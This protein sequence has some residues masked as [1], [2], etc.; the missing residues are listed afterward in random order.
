MKSSSPASSVVVCVCGGGGVGVEGGV[1]VLVGWG[2]VGWGVV[3]DG[4][5]GGW[6]WWWVLVD[7]GWWD[8]VEVGYVLVEDVVFCYQAQLYEW[9]ISNRQGTPTINELW[10]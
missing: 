7:G 8:G 10:K 6:G 3:V 2:V 5:G 9:G 1:G 4:G